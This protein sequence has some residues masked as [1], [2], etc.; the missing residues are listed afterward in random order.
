MELVG[1]QVEGSDKIEYV[2]ALF[3]QYLANNEE[4]RKVI[5]GLLVAVNVIAITLSLTTGG[6]SLLAIVVTGLNVIIATIDTGVLLSDDD[7]EDAVWFKE[8]WNKL[9]QVLAVGS[10]S[11]LAYRIVRHGPT[12]LLRLQ[13]KTGV[14]VARL[15]AAIKTVTVQ[16]FREFEIPNFKTGSISVFSNYKELKKYMQSASIAEREYDALFSEG[17]IF[18]KAV[19]NTQKADEAIVLLYNAEVIAEGT[20]KEVRNSLKPYKGLSKAKLIEALIR[21]SK[22]TKIFVAN[23]KDIGKQANKVHFN[24]IDEFG[25]AIGELLRTVGAQGRELKYNLIQKGEKTALD[26]YTTLLNQQLGKEFSLP[27]SHGETILFADFNVPKRITDEFSGFGGIMLDDALAFY[28]MNKK[29]TKVDGTI[30]HWLKSE[31][32][33]SNYGGESINLTQ[34]WNAVNFK[35]MTYEQAAFETF[36]GRWAKQ[37]G[38]TKVEY[39]LMGVRPNKV[40]IKF[41]D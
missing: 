26:S 35:K 9:M 1:L 4:W 37:N 41:I 16:A 30:G 14:Q 7:S 18:A 40:T 13:G 15:R 2:P 36:S 22:R 3:I 38:F 27:V 29:F 6:A 32:L 24:I 19:R 21:R 10:L 8:N 33:Y 20:S 17:V 25:N 34:F 11:A 31:T 28:N 23:A 5:V 39:K 12:M